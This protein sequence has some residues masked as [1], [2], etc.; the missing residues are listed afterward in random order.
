MEQTLPSGGNRKVSDGEHLLMR[1]NILG[2]RQ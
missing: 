2:I 1:Q